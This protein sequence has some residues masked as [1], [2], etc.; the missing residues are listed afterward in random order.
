MCKRTS[1]LPLK[2]RSSRS[3][4]VTILVV[5]ALIPLGGCTG[6]RQPPVIAPPP[7][8]SSSV[9]P[10]PPR[11]AAVKPKKPSREAHTADRGTPPVRTASID[12]QSLLGLDPDGV[13]KRLGPPARMQNSALSREWVYSVPGCSFSIFFYPNLNSTSFR[14]L[15]YGST[16]D[17]GES[18][19]SSDACVRKILTARNN[20]D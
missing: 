17:N 7:V 14:V 10:T 5:L 18:I 11:A 8:V 4:G 9:R 12:P 15:K 1:G 20:A 3:P 2:Q 16:R 19:D 13:Q 6:M